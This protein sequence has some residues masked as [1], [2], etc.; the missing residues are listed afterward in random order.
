[1]HL[2]IMELVQRCPNLR[3]LDHCDYYEKRRDY[4]R[5]VIIREGLYGENVRY[6]VQRPP[7][8]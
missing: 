3:Q 7:S 4:K 6:E 2:A 8:R 1:M 5:I